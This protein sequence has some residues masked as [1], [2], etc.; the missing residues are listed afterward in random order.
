MHSYSV[1]VACPR[2]ALT[3]YDASYGFLASL[4]S[5]TKYILNAILHNF[6]PIFSGCTFHWF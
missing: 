2:M 1:S 4:N 5:I 6:K 3:S